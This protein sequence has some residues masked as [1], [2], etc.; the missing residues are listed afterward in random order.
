MLLFIDNNM[1]V[2]YTENTGFESMNCD[3]KQYILIH[4]KS[5]NLCSVVDLVFFNF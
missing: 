4:K 3:L 2:D 1:P 5:Y